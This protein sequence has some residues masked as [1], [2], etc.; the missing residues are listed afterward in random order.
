MLRQYFWLL[1]QS[2]NKTRNDILFFFK[3]TKAWPFFSI[4]WQIIKWNCL[5]LKFLIHTEV[6]TK[7]QSDWEIGF[8][9]QKLNESALSNYGRFT[10]PKTEPHQLLRVSN[11]QVEY[12]LSRTNNNIIGNRW[13]MILNSSSLFER[14]L[15]PP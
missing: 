14:S 10:N 9:V 3:K 13:T 2:K 7:P 8:Q 1:I 12:E 6:C 5:E 11:C 15:F 4:R